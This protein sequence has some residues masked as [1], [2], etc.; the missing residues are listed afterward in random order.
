MARICVGKRAAETKPSVCNQRREKDIPIPLVPPARAEDRINQMPFQAVLA[1]GSSN[2]PPVAGVD[3]CLKR[4]RY[5]FGVMPPNGRVPNTSSFCPSAS[6]A[7]SATYGFSYTTR[8]VSPRLQRS[9]RRVR[10]G[11]FLMSSILGAT[12]ILTFSSKRRYFACPAMMCLP[13][14]PVL[15]APGKRDWP[16]PVDARR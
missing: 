10:T 9:K 16:L 5:S 8:C 14:A 2:S 4:S 1:G 7:P 12:N 6:F 15:P 11:E 3:A 13:G